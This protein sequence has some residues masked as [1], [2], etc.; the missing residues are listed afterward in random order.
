MRRFITCCIA[1]SLL[2]G[3]FGCS[4]G[5]RDEGASYDGPPKAGG[6]LIVAVQDDGQTLDPHRATDAASMR[7]IE[8][9][10]ATLMRYTPQ[11]GQVEPD[12]TQELKISDDGLVYTITLRPNLTFHSGRP[13]TAEDVKFSI[14]R[15]IEQQVRAD[16]FAMVE[17]IEAVDPATVKLH[18]SRPSAPLLTHLAYPMN[19]I[20]DRQTVQEAGGDLSNADAG[21]GPFAL[22]EWR[23]NRHLKLK[24]HAGYHVEGR[25]YLD[26]VIFRPIPDETARTTALRNGE[27]H[28][29]LDLAAK[30]VKIVQ[31]ARGVVIQSVPGTFW[32]YI[33]LN[34]SK[35][36]FDDVRVR[37]AIAHA[38]DREALNR[39]IKLSRA[40]PLDGGHIPPNHWAY[41]ANLHPYAKRDLDR[42]RQLLSEAG[43]G[44]GFSSVMKVGSSFKYQVDAAQMVKQQLAEVG[45]DVQI[46]AL[47]SGLFFDALNRRDFEMTLVGWLGFV[48][49]DEWTYNLFHSDGKYNQQAFSN[50]EL[51]A[52]LEQGRRT[53]DQ[54]ARRQIYADI[55]W[56][57]AT[58]APVVSLYVN[59]QTSAWR[60]EV[61]GYVV[62]PTA[63][64]LWLR[65]TW[66]A[67]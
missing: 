4:G 14:E 16:H 34:T 40:T 26:E 39:I 38:I 36:P 32:E 9:M 27:V 63:T 28:L 48:D 67:K 35:A 58:E 6:A 52:L 47:E 53:L 17:R 56:I 49:P 45:I 22:V 5:D 31:N 13:V 55:Q 15:I 10:Y 65:E 7:L 21:C 8:N 59:D 24:K 51:D 25:P 60:S 19:A 64:T 61:R 1:A 37:Q 2:L 57:I 41:A 46:Q 42:A 43:L 33:G 30:D 44:G 20:V 29:V 54:E 3:L 66:L 50:A 12:M 23:K 62:H 11:Y 18:L